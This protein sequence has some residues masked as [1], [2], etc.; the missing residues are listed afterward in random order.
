MKITDLVKFKDICSK[1]DKTALKSLLEYLAFYR[2]LRELVLV[3]AINTCRKNGDVVPKTET[4][5]EYSN[6]MEG[7]RILIGLIGRKE[8]AKVYGIMEGVTSDM[9]TVDYILE[10]DSVQYYKDGLSVNIER[11]EEVAEKRE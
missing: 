5:E 6:L 11:K 9:K 10:N 3:D 1:Y 2:I 7:E 4:L 8:S